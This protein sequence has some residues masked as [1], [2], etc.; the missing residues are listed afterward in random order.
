MVNDSDWDLNLTW[1]TSQSTGACVGTPGGTQQHHHHVCASTTHPWQAEW[2]L[3]GQWKT[4][5][6]CPGPVPI[7]EHF[8]HTKQQGRWKNWLVICCFKSCMCCMWFWLPVQ[9]CVKARGQHL[10]TSFITPWL[11]RVSYWA[12]SSSLARLAGQQAL[13]IYLSLFPVTR[14]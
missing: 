9:V 7:G 6:V 5:S 3:L 12:Q 10:V 14:L 13:E 8:A 4:Q 2:L 11:D 1:P